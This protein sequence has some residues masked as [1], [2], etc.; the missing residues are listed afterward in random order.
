VSW[1]RTVG[2][3]TGPYDPRLGGTQLAGPDWNVSAAN[4]DGPLPS[5]PGGRAFVE[6]ERIG[7][8]GDVGVTVA[9][10]LAIGSGAPRSVL[11]ATPTGVA[12]LIPRGGDGRGPLVAQANVR[13]AARWRGMTATLDVINAF[14]RREVTLLDES[15]S[16][17]VVHPISG[18]SYEDLVFLRT[19]AGAPARRLTTFQLPT[20]FQP[21]LSISLGVHKVF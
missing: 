15:Y 17:D 7:A 18:G 11:A 13:L 21:P 16:G 3:W 14:D 9:T 20:A 10:R 1:G 2:T 5:D 4:L 6:A 8:L 19:D 12:L